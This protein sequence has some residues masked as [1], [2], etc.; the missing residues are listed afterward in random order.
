MFSDGGMGSFVNVYPEFC[1]VFRSQLP[2]A[3]PNEGLFRALFRI[4]PNTCLRKGEQ[5]A[6]K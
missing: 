2:S 3:F 1:Q 4:V 6:I 5:S